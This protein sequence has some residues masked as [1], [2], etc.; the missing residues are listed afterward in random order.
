[1]QIDRRAFN[2]KLRKLATPIAF[3]SLMLP[4]TP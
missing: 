2:G 4:A 1:M 3:Q